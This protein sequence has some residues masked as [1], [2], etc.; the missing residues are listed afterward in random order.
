MTTAD[1]DFY[2]MSNL[3]PRRTGLPFAVWISPRG[4]AKHDVRVK[5]SL[6]PKAHPDELVTVAVRP[7]VAVVAG[8]LPAAQL[9]LLRQWIELNRD[10]LVKFWEGEIEYTEDIL[11]ELRP[12]E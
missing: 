1:V 6:G 7:D 11:G 10:A 12:I 8:E 3:S 4:G 9:K 5:V 2:L